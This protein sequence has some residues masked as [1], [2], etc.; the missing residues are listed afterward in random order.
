[1]ANSF[2]IDGDMV[3][4]LAELLQETGLSEIEIAEGDRRIRVTR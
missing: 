4:Q 1:M 2:E 3:R